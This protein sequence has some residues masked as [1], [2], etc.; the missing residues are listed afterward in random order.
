MEL[1]WA[2]HP[3]AALRLRLAFYLGRGWKV[4]QLETESALLARPK[5]WTKPSWLFWNGFYLLYLFRKDRTDRIRLTLGPTGD[6]IE[7]RA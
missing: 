5:G 2:N 1:T 4:E 6:V 7:A 3:N